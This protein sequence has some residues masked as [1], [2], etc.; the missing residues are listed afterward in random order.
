M[1]GARLS[2]RRARAVRDALVAH[3]V[4]PDRLTARGYGDTRPLVMPRTDADRRR[5][6]RIELHLLPPPPPPPGSVTSRP[7]HLPPPG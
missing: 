3:G 2:D 4:A 7:R 1:R 5:N 6:T